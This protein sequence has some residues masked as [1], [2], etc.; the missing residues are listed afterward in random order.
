MSLD[1][2]LTAVRETS[3]FERNIT[4]NLN[5]MADEAGIYGVIWR[6]EE[7]G[8]ETAAQLIEPLRTGMALLK[9]N[10][11]RFKALNPPNGWGRYEGLVTFVEAYLA[12]CIENPDATVE[13]S[14]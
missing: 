6:P 12:A 3:V 1:I 13:A 11:D 14:R 5:R 4:H 7:N 2:T 10:P 9:A 8:I